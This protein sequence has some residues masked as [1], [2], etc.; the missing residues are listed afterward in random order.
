M[1]LFNDKTLREEYSREEGERGVPDEKCSTEK[2]AF[3][4]SPEVDE[5]V[6]S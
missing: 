1:L 6:F 2:L 4:Y 3:E 5:G